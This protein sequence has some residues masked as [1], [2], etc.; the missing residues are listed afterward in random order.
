MYR[1]NCLVKIAKELFPLRRFY[2]IKLVLERIYTK[3][4]LEANIEAFGCSDTANDCQYFS[5][6]LFASFFER[7]LKALMSSLVDCGYFIRTLL[8]FHSRKIS[9]FSYTY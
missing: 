2:S 8:R 4:R 6:S 3:A 1:W 7:W 9:G 5:S